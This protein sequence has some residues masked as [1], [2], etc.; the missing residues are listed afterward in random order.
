MRKIILY[1]I[2]LLIGI[3][4]YSIIYN[5]YEAEQDKR[6]RLEKHIFYDSVKISILSDSIAK[7]EGYIKVIEKALRAN[8]NDK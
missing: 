5:K 7:Q 1:T 2:I 4:L 3:V 8:D 6:T